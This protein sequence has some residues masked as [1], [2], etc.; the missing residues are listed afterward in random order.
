MMFVTIIGRAKTSA[1]MPGL[2]PGIQVSPLMRN[3]VDGRD[4]CAKT[5]FALLPGHDEASEFAS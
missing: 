2:E 4:I 1:V 3:D 5:R